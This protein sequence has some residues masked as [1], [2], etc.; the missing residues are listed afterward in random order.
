MGSRAGRRGSVPLS[1]INR[2]IRTQ[3]N[4]CRGQAALVSRRRRRDASRALASVK[5][6]TFTRILDA[7]NARAT[8]LASS[9]RRNFRV[10]RGTAGS[11]RQISDW[12]MAPV[13]P[14]LKPRPFFRGRNAH[15]AKERPSLTDLT[16]MLSRAPLS[17]QQRHH[18]AA[19]RSRFSLR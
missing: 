8:S 3:Y 18:G 5:S 14:R 1:P 19:H 2:T 17:N 15:L 12:N 10:G 6:S 16:T 4:R 7:W 11:G 9:R 13:A